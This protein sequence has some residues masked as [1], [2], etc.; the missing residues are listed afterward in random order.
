MS[1]INFTLFIDLICIEA[2]DYEETVTIFSNF[3]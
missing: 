1:V 2:I 3:I